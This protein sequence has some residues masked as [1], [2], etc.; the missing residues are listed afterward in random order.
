MS[1]PDEQKHR[2]EEGQVAQERDIRAGFAILLDGKSSLQN[3]TD[4]RISFKG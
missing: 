1:T 4:C 2:A 3:G